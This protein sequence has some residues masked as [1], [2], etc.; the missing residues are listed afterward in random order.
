MNK[1]SLSI[2]RARHEGQASRAIVDRNIERL[3][4]GRKRGIEK[5]V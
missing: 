5:E 1:G 4:M 2:S 3:F